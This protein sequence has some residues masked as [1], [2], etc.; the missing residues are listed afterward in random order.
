MN[1]RTIVSLVLSSVALLLLVA[2]P[3]GAAPVVLEA[4]FDSTLGPNQ[5]VVDFSTLG[6]STAFMSITGGEFAMETDPAA[7]TA[8]LLSWRQ[9]VEPIEILPGLSTG[10][11]VVTMEAGSGTEG[12]YDAA[13]RQ[14]SASATFLINFDDTGLRDFGFVSPMPLVGTEAGYI[15][16][17]ANAIRMYLEGEGS[18]QGQSFQYTCQTTARFEYLLEEDQAMPGDV[19]VDRITD[20]SDP[21]NI[22]GS[23]FLGGS[24]SCSQAADVNGENGVDL[25]DAVYLLSYLFIGG[26]ATPDEPVTCTKE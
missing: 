21:M 2:V 18:V 17:S 3:V 24:M 11:I 8:R 15:Y 9:Q 1:Q 16:G 14:F 10:P 5:Y 6:G 7:G 12:T 20:I 19:N 25:S 22:L 23:L 13:T 4:E 26:P